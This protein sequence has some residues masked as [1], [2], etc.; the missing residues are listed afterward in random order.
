MLFHLSLVSYLRQTRRLRDTT[1]KF[2]I[3]DTAGQKRY[4]TLAQMYFRG[5]QATIVVYSITDET[6]FNRAKHWVKELQ[7]KA[8]HYMVMALAG[9]TDADPPGERMVTFEVIAQHW[10][11]HRFPVSIETEMLQW[12]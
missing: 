8:S 11:T 5:A 6:T 1:V 4:N 10:L 12:S 2:E 7:Q 9:N 3:W